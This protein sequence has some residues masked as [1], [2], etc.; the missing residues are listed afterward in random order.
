MRIFRKIRIRFYSLDF[1]TRYA[2]SF[3]WTGLAILGLLF[4]ATYE[5]SYFL[6][7]PVLMLFALVIG[8]KRMGFFLKFITISQMLF[9]VSDVITNQIDIM[10][11]IMIELLIVLVGPIFFEEHAD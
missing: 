10:R 9:L 11:I 2:I 4:G 6:M 3:V 8:Y 1:E 7:I 5:N